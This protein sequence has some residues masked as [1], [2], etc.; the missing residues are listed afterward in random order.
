M[1]NSCPVL[2][3]PALSHWLNGFGTFWRAKRGG[4]TRTGI[5]LRGARGLSRLEEG[6]G[7]KC[8]DFCG[9]L[10]QAEGTAHGEAQRQ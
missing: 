5:Q 4:G 2:M 9:R 6:Q 8:V 3:G 10:F 1:R 7:V